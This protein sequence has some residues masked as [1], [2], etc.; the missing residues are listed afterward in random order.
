MRRFI[1]FAAALL[2]TMGAASSRAGDISF[3][4]TIT[5]PVIPGVYG[6]VVIGNAPPPPVVYAHPMVIQPPPP[7]VVFAPIY[8]HVPPEHARHWRA[9]CHE[10]HACNRPVY[11]VRSAEYEPGFNMEKWRREH[12]DHDHGRWD[13]NR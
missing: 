1:S 4:L 6:H 3:G 12:H 5:G 8:L 7:G 13:Q 10:Y 11:F 9:H 2:C